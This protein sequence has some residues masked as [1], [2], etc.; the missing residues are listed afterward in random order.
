MA[1]SGTQIEGSYHVCMYAYV[2]IYVYVV[3]NY[4]PKSVLY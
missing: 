1:I 2:Y 4:A 3:R